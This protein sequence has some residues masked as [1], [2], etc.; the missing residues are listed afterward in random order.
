MIHYEI[1][2]EYR[3]HYDSYDMLSEHGQVRFL[4]TLPVSVL[5]WS[6]R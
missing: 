2:Q 4:P 5:F 3:P 1:E 6:N